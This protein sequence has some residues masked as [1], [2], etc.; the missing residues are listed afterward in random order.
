MRVGVR[1]KVL[2]RRSEGESAQRASE[3]EGVCEV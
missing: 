2:V 3:G 1:V